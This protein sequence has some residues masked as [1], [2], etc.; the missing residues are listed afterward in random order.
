MKLLHWN[1]RAQSYTTLEIEGN[2]LRITKG[3][4]GVKDAVSI[5][6]MLTAEE[7]LRLA[8]YFE[9]YVRYQD[10]QEIRRLMENNNKQGG[11]NEQ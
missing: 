11:K 9:N 7:M 2:K 8:Y 10:L 1:E 4:K 6:M 3:T 5:T